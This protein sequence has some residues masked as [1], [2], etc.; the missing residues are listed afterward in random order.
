MWLYAEIKILC[1]LITFSCI[2]LAS[3]YIFKMAAVTGCYENFIINNILN[4]QPILI[5]FAQ[6]LFVYKCL[7]FQTHLPLDLRF[8]LKYSCF[9]IGIHCLHVTKCYMYQRKIPYFFNLRNTRRI[10]TCK[11]RIQAGG[12]G[13]VWGSGGSLEP[14]PHP[15]FFNILWKWNNL[16]SV[17]PNY[18]ISMGYLR[19]MR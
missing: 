19:K 7:S 5:K 10:I 4:S 13:G 1:I 8:P 17:R 16:V 15:P 12:G 2:P 18:F 14:P 6:K 9:E 11:L 3:Y